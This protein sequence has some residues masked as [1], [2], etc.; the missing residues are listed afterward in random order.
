VSDVDG[1]G[2]PDL[3]ASISSG[4][5]WSTVWYENRLGEPTADF[6]PPR[7]I[8]TLGSFYLVTADLDGDGDPDIVAKTFQSGLSWYDNRLRE[9]SAI[10]APSA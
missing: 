4:T 7:T 8:S 9:P 3:V 10:S 6:A 5:V 2:D 1:D